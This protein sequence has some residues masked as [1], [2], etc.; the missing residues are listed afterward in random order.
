MDFEQEIL[1]LKQRNLRV[2]TEKEWERSFTRR[3]FIS[4][5]TYIIAL[6]WLWIIKDSNPLLKS[7][8]PVAGYILSTLSLPII[9]NWWMQK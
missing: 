6:V 3:F 4:F 1:A 2:E 9:K 7:F 5:L 8:V